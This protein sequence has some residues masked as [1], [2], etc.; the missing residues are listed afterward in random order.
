MVLP[1]IRYVMVSKLPGM[2]GERL[3]ERLKYN[4]F[5]IKYWM[6]SPVQLD[7]FIDYS[8]ANLL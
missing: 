8:V 6:L 4:T 5:W 1:V 3:V 2:D 7:K